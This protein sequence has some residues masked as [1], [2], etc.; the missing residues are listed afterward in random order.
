M[1]QILRHWRILA[2]TLFSVVLIA[3]VYVLARGIESPSLAQASAETA[4]LRA[5][6]T[7]DSTGDGLPDWQKV[8]YGIPLTSTTTDYFNLGMTDGEAVAKGLIVPKAIADI[9]IDTS[10]GKAVSDPSF[11]PAGEGS[12]TEAFAKS[13]FMLYVNA[14]QASGGTE[15]SASQVNDLATQSLDSLSELVSL[16]PDYKSMSDLTVSGSGSDALRAFAAS[17]DAVILK[18]KKMSDATKSDIL[19][20]QDVLERNDVTALP[21]IASIAKMY[22]DSAAGLAILPVPSELAPDYLALVNAMMRASG[23]ASDFARVNT[24]AL[25]AMLALNQYASVNH[26]VNQAFGNMGALYA[27]AGVTL[28]A[29]EPGALFLQT[30]N[31]FRTP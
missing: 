29:G 5:I 2:A 24:D 10:S 20:L 16:A 14:K 6:A 18:N 27:A 23:I 1:G 3:G 12:L 21:H 13:F 26:A 25:A 9:S 15:L 8:L 22:R 31:L 4:L 17:I 11:P 28:S 7:R 30:I 19:Y